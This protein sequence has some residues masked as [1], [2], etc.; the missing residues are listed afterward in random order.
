MWKWECGMR[1]IGKKVRAACCGVRGAG[2]VLRVAG[3]G[4]RVAGYGVRIYGHRA[5]RIGQRRLNSE[6]G[7]RKAE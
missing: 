3:C 7:M 2:Y 5:W 6:L 1:K 4:V